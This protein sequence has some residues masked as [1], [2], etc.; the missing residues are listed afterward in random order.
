MWYGRQPLLRTATGGPG[1]VFGPLAPPPTSG[2]S[3]CVATTGN[4]PTNSST[5]ATSTGSKA[6]A[7]PGSDRVDV[8]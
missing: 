4:Q 5:T 2:T 8:D 3:A 7:T 6:E 1:R